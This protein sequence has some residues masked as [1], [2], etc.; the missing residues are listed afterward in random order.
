[1]RS[2]SICQIPVDKSE[3]SG[4]PI[5]PRSGDARRIR[6]LDSIRGIAALVVILHHYWPGIVPFGWISV[7]LFF[8]LSGYLITSIILKG[9]REDHFLVNF[10]IRRSL[11]I[12]PIYY[13]T[14]ALI[15]FVVPRMSQPDTLTDFIYFMTYTQFTPLYWS[16]KV[17]RLSGMGHTWTLAIEEQF[18]L[19]WP[20]LILTAGRRRAWGVVLASIL[21]AVTMRS[22]RFHEFL[23]ASRCD[24][25]ALGGALAL[26]LEDQSWVS[27]YRRI[28]I[29][30]MIG[31]LVGLLP[32]LAW[33]MLI[34]GGTRALVTLP[35][36]RS[37]TM[38]GINATFFSLVGLIVLNEGALALK[39]LRNPIL[40][41]MGQISYGLYLYH[42]PILIL[43]PYIIKGSGVGVGNPALILGL[44]LTFVVSMLSWN[45]LERPILKLRER[46][47]YRVDTSRTIR[48]EP[49]QPGP[50]QELES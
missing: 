44:A 5:V 16:E 26:L 41:Y 24:G 9:V 1:M 10:Y 40:S 20:A 37:L 17:T 11:R 27:R 8:V 21:L 46:L 47:E 35:F 13:L 45:F 32:Y 36:C 25:L 23:L 19:I 29:R 15:F 18:Y 49:V 6:E 42:I 28:L 33:V 50:S 39:P 31:S 22:L 7:D 14:L 38:L 43:V 30:S 12:W 34:L 2:I 4:R 48:R 3:V